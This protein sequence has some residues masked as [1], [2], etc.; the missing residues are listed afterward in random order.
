MSPCDN[1][2]DD[3]H[4]AGHRCVTLSPMDRDGPINQ[5]SIVGEDH[6]IQWHKHKKP[7]PEPRTERDRFATGFRSTLMPPHDWD[8]PSRSSLAA[9]PA[10]IPVETQHV[11]GPGREKSDEY[12]D[13]T[14]TFTTDAT[15][16][17]YAAMPYLM[18][19]SFDRLAE[20]N[21]PGRPPPN[22]EHILCIYLPLTPRLDAQNHSRTC[23]LQSLATTVTHLSFSIAARE[24][25]PPKIGI[26][27]ALLLEALSGCATPDG[28]RYA[29]PRSSDKTIPDPTEASHAA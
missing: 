24:A 6:A 29:P 5:R 10:L 4:D 23:C 27:F 25:S 2:H 1:A 17:S 19:P 11:L 12:L 3:H 20:C 16:P 21:A 26:S 14:Q 13:L 18:G 22:H 9:A 7:Q 15:V 28:V 8:R